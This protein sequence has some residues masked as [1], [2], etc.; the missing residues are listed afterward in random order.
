VAQ[1]EHDRGVGAPLEEP[2]DLAV[3]G[4]VHLDDGI[5]APRR[6][7]GAGMGRVVE[8]PALMSDAVRRAEHRHQGIEAAFV[9]DA[10]QELPLGSHAG[11][12][13]VDH[14]VETARPAVDV[15]VVELDRVPVDDRRRPRPGRPAPVVG[16][17]VD[18]LHPV[19]QPGERHERRVDH[20]DTSAVVVE[21][22]PE[23]HRPKRLGVDG[24]H[25]VTGRIGL[26]VAV[27][28]VLGGRQ[29]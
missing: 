1:V 20:S 4:F 11:Q 19:A 13:R 15:A 5:L 6:R 22:L 17:E 24:T 27:G 14:V 16:V 12:Q 7:A 28:P 10:L 25:R 18:D 26:R 29:P 8:V 3:D 23:Q 2:P 9:D 21:V